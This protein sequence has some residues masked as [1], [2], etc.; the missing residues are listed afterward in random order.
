MN[1]EDTQQ[2]QS[3]EENSLELE[4]LKEI[5]V[6]IENNLAQVHKQS[7]FKDETIDRLQK[8]VY[9]YEKG[10]IPSI[11]EP[12][13]KDLILFKDS[14]NKFR[15]MFSESSETLL[16]EI[17]FLNDEIED[18]F[19]THDVD[20]IQVEGDDYDRELQIVR[21]KIPTDNQALHRKIVEVLKDGYKSGEKILRKQEVA[22]YI[23][24]DQTSQS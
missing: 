5:K 9:S 1:P 3:E 14:F 13:L 7:S 4:F 23:I 10:F 6:L 8:L 20:I 17:D 16:R 24:N 22:V 19:Y 15:T 18:I 12:L 2:P 21:K 11:K